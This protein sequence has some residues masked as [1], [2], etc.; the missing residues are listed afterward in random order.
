[1]CWKY[2]QGVKENG[3][4]IAVKKLNDMQDMDDK[5]FLNEVK[6]VMDICHPNIVR[7]AGYCYQRDGELMSVN[8]SYI[9]V[10]KVYRLL[11]FEYLPNGSLDKHLAG[12]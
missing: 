4:V 10:D 7:G 2:K 1:M 12:M 11:C 6:V 8:G 5:Q 3:E 9:V